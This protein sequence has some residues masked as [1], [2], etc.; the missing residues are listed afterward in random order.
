[1]SRNS[2]LETAT[3]SE[4]L[5]LSPIIHEIP[6]IGV[7]LDSTLSFTIR[8]FTWGLANYLDICKDV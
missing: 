7:S 1:M 8:V 2:L 4:V 5:G 6:E 3:I